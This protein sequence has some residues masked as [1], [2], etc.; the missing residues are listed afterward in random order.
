MTEQNDIE[1]GGKLGTRLTKVV[2]DALVYTR[3]R[4]GPHQAGIAQT[5]LADFT[6]HVSDEIRGVMGPIWLEW[7]ESPE[8]PEQF[9]PLFKAL[10]TERGQAWAWIA[11]N[12]TG[13]ATASTLGDMFGNVL[14][15][16]VQAVVEEFPNALLSPEVVANVIARGL[17]V[18][19]PEIP[20]VTEAA[21]GGMNDARL[22]YLIELA[23]QYPPLE[24]LVEMYRRKLINRNDFLHALTRVGVPEG[25]RSKLI[26]LSHNEMT[27]PDISAMW[28]RSIVDTDTA[29]TLGAKL[30]YDDT[31]VRRALE[32]GGEPLA[33]DQ[34]AEAF[35]RGFID[36]DRYNRGIIQGPIRNE[37]FDVLAQLQFHRM[38]PVDAADA[39]NQGHMPLE[40]G[41]RIAHEHGLDSDD[42]VTLIE[43]AGAPPGIDFATEA[44]NRK[45]IDEATFTAM[46]L[47]SRIKNKY[48]PLLLKMRTRLIPQETARLAYR[49]GV[50]SRDR[51]LETLLA[52]GF[53][54]DDAA[55][56]LAIED[57][58]QDETTKEL[59]RAQI[60]Q[61]YDEQILDA[62]TTRQLLS[63][64]GYSE[65][66]VDL[67]MA[68][69]EV[70]R[71]QRFVNAA[72]TRVRSAYLTGKIDENEVSIQLDALAV[73]S[74]QRE[75][76][77]TIWSID[78]TTITK[79]LTP[80]Q[81][82]QAVNRELILRDA[83][84]E[85]L[86]LQGYNEID[87]NLYLDLS[88]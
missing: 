22:R 25:W 73:P 88:A 44:L 12:A 26:E 28:N 9:R 82:R 72:I 33:P 23:R 60:V 7:A 34:L 16:M 13:A 37:W 59:T 29:I 61:M 46:F 65:A 68:L 74:S 14:A 35:R 30:G 52:H 81:I 42:F 40:V 24:V 50:Y 55:T 83:G 87:A 76:L 53:T 36:R 85:R 21:K 54:P 32:L 19:N 63:G 43:T 31:Q 62:D 11:G 80:A 18:E 8:T 48:G 5:V 64:L 66:N 39:I 2:A 70:K 41:K 51:A 47:E 86:I 45:F 10:G 75:E 78:R 15:P 3:Q 6:N 27:L 20:M 38:S 79:T 17:S 49:Q 56:L 77:L 58:R 4:L 84:V 69:A 67:M 57:S 1:L 71:V